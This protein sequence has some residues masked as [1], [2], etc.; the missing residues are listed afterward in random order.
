[1]RQV[2]R[3]AKR[4][5]VIGAKIMGATLWCW[6]FWRLKHDWRELLVSVVTLR[7]VLFIIVFEFVSIDR[8]L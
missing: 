8:S 2:L 6:I 1:M 3:P 5:H 4:I 7:A